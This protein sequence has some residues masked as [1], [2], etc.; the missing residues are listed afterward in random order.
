MRPGAATDTHSNA[1]ALSHRDPTGATL[2]REHRRESS[3]SP[4]ATDS[5]APP[6]SGDTAGATPA[7]C[8]SRAK[9]TPAPSE[10]PPTRRVA[11]PS[12]DQAASHTASAVDTRCAGAAAEADSQPTEHDACR[13]L[14]ATWNT[15]PRPTQPARCATLRTTAASRYW[16]T[17][18][19]AAEP[20]RRTRAKPWCAWRARP[21]ATWC[22]STAR[23]RWCAAWRSAPAGW[24]WAPC[25]TW[26]AATCRRRARWA[27]SRPPRRRRRTWCRRRWRCARRPFLRVLGP[28]LSSGLAILRG[29]LFCF[30]ISLCCFLHLSIMFHLAVAKF[31]WPDT[32]LL[33]D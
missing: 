3:N 2:P 10:E 6:A 33:T 23:R 15:V 8:A 25:S 16:N 7:T 13:L 9:L 17:T 11:G 4:P 26:R 30:M 28:I 29:F 21:L 31:A 18:S 1:A 20:S 27:G 32:D 24:A 19:P 22:S 14:P 5:T 12:S